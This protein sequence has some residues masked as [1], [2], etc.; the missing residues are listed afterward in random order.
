MTWK[1]KRRPRSFRVA[2]RHLANH[3]RAR[4]PFRDSFS[5]ILASELT[6]MV[7]RYYKHDFS[8]NHAIVS[9]PPPPGS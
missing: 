6:L 9:R 8:K 1:H 5:K 3:V 7:R 2:N 4:H